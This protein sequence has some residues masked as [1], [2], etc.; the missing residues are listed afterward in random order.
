[1]RPPLLNPLFAALA[2]LS[3]IGPKLGKL[4]AHLLDRDPPKLVDLLFHMPSVA[5]DRNAYAPSAS[6]RYLPFFDRSRESHTL[7]GAPF[8]GTAWMPCRRSPV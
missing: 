8:F 6:A 4:Y 7:Y 5:I 1:M 2:T 3:G